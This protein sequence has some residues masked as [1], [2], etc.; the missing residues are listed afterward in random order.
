[1]R[2]LK[3]KAEDEVRENGTNQFDSDRLQCL[4]SVLLDQDNDMRAAIATFV[5][6]LRYCDVQY[7]TI[8]SLHKSVRELKQQNPDGHISKHLSINVASILAAIRF[9][10]LRD[11]SSAHQV[12]SFKHFCST[13]GIRF[14]Y[15][16]VAKMFTSTVTV[17][18]S[19]SVRIP[20]SFRCL[21][22]LIVP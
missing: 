7:F 3:K 11:P 10:N 6:Y 13:S 9:P 8:R 22:S 16:M 1:M 12:S 17:F 20:L 4:L 14:K 2:D 19:F 21:L 5:R 18:L 15:E